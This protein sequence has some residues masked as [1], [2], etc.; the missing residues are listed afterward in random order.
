[1]PPVEDEVYPHSS[2]GGVS[3][4]FDIGD[5]IGSFV[6]A[7]GVGASAVKTLNDDAVD[8]IAIL[9]SENAIVAV[10][11]GGQDPAFTA[12]TWVPDQV[13]VLPGRPTSVIVR[14]ATFKTIGSAVGTLY[15]QIFRKWETLDKEVLQTRT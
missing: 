8:E 4:P 12:D 13:I 11:F 14:E 15:V 5:A 7:V 2:K 1:M 9:Y 10:R 6:T 3:I